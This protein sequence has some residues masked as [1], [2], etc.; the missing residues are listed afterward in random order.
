MYKNTSPLKFP[1]DFLWGG[2][3]A[4]NQVEGAWNEDGKGMTIE[5]CL[6][7][8]EV[9]VADFTKQFQFSSRDL[10]EALTAGPDANYPKDGESTSIT[11]TRKILNYLRKWAIR[12]SVCPF[13][14]RESLQTQEMR[15]PM[16]MVSLFTRICLRNVKNMA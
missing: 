10:E 12:Y 13:P 14:G 3:T 11:I 9:G 15:S 1:N 4:A 2:A 8:R 5:D 6:P 16:R 7:Y